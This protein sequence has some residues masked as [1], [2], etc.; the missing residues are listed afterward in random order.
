MQRAGVLASGNGTILQA[1]L[2]CAQDAYR[3]VAVASNNPR[4]RALERAGSRGIDA[5]FIR[6]GG[7]LLAHFQAHNVDFVI[8]DGYMRMLGA[9]FVEFYR[10]RIINAHCSLI[11]AFC[12]KGFY[13][14]KVHEAV[15]ERGVKVTGATVHFVNEEYD[16]GPII[17]QKAV[18]VEDGDTPETLQQRVLREA[19]WLIVPEAARLF[20]EGKLRIEG[21][22]VAVTE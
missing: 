17:L 14:L 9:D 1:L 15:L 13:G 20:A 12:G 19:E 7:A 10:N 3:V 22:R 8:L 5:A 18:P 16:A 6:D 4:A 11:P 21:N 2:D